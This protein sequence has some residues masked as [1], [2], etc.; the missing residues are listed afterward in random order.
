M[1]ARFKAFKSTLHW[2][3]Q[4]Q[5]SVLSTSSGTITGPAGNQVN[6]SCNSTIT[7]SCLR[8][9]YNAVS[10]NT[11]A[12]NGNELGLTAYLGQYANNMDLQQF[13]ELENPSAYGSN[14]TFVSV[15]GILHSK[16]G[17]YITD[18]FYRWIKQPD[19]CGGRR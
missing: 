6:A 17:N 15:N 7:V 8:E 13:F 19:L 2:G 10:Y 18:V 3:N 11:S 9:L 16:I 4:V 5:P 12:T 1:F 14:Y